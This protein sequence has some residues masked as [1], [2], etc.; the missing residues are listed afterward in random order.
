MQK[1]VE[2]KVEN[3]CICDK[4]RLDKCENINRRMSSLTLRSL[5]FVYVLVHCKN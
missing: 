3:V 4:H 5:G 2:L 1:E